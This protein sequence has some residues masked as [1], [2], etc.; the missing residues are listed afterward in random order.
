MSCNLQYSNGKLTGV[1]DEQGNPSKLYQEAKN[2][3][4]EEK[5]LEIYLVSK[6]DSFIEIFN[7]DEPSLQTVLNYIAQNNRTEESL[8][9]EE[10]LDVFNASLIS[11]EINPKDFYD[12][13][14]LFIIPKKYYTN[15]EYSN[16]VDDIELQKKVKQTV[17]KMLNTEEIVISDTRVENPE[18][19]TQVTAL[20]KLN[21]LN[22]NV[23]RQ[24]ILDLAVQNLS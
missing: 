23:V 20:G 4:G 22:P 17:D 8:S 1:F 12:K 2:K 18:K 13:D 11:G 21:I 16:L 24:E 6:S 19:T 15:Y 7:Q 5:G 9:K 10:L 14:G 3:F